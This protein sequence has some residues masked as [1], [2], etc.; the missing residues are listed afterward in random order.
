MEE[1]CHTLLNWVANL[2]NASFN[3]RNNFSLFIIQSAVD[4]FQRT[5]SVNYES[6]S[7]RPKTAT[8]ERESLEVLLHF[9][10]NR[11][12]SRRE[13]RNMLE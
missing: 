4:S 12:T 3:D 11:H 9:Q 6:R 13:K 2:V 10:D 1:L 5:G 7:G 8:D